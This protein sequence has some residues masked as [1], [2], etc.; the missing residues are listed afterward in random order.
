MP[1]DASGNL[2]SSCVVRGLFRRLTASQAVLTGVPLGHA[3][4]GEERQGGA[5]KDAEDKAQRPEASP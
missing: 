1:K 4:L 2:L 3:D 5:K